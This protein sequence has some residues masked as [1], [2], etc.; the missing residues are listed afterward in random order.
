MMPGF[1]L[2][3]I[4]LRK[5]HKELRKKGSS[6]LCLQGD[7]LQIWEEL[8]SRFEI[9]Q[10]Y[11]NKDYEPYAIERDQK[12]KDLLQKQ[13][14]ELLTYKDQVIFEENEVMKN[15]GKPYT[16]FTPYKNKWLETF[17]NNNPDPSEAINTFEQLLNPSRPSF[18]F[19]N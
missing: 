3:M 11:I 17:K 15:D 19:I 18:S 7:P 14:I 6:L 10:V 13:G 2:Y 12:V 5:L 1:L 16:V 4:T 8:I 9:A